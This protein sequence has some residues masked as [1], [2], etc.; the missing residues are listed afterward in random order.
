MRSSVDEP[1][2][3]SYCLITVSSCFEVIVSQKLARVIQG[4]YIHE[5]K[6]TATERKVFQ[7]AVLLNSALV[8][9]RPDEPRWPKLQ[10][11]VIKVVI[12]IRYP[13]TGHSKISHLSS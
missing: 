11:A 7:I 1:V 8:N 5:T 6:G 4:C 9:S 12:P 3:W 2:T 10:L 13:V